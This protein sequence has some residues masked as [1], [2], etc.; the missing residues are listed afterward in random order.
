MRQAAAHAASGL[1]WLCGAPDWAA[2]AVI[3][4][5]SDSAVEGLEQDARVVPAEA[6]A[7]GE[8]YFDVHL[9]SGVDT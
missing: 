4:Q 8:R 5:R 7:V 1:C 2:H 3:A 9:Q 6:E